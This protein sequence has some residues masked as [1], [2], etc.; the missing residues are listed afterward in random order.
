[1][2]G[3][4]LYQYELDRQ[5]IFLVLTL[6]AI[7]KKISSTKKLWFHFGL[8]KIWCFSFLDI[9]ESFET[10]LKFPSV[11]ALVFVVYLLREPSVE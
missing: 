1:M 6:F 4:I 2:F 11:L 10:L 9:L 7:L 3:T 8:D 5:V